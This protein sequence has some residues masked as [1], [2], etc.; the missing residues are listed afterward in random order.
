LTEN[1]ATIL[2]PSIGVGWKYQQQPAQEVDFYESQRGERLA[3]ADLVLNR[4][5]RETLLIELGYS[6]SNIATAVRNNNK[7]RHQRKQTVMNLGS[8]KYEEVLEGV[9]NRGKRLWNPFG[10]RGKAAAK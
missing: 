10:G 1:P 5:Q 6:S 2:G 3:S 8:A 4:E 7:V 9:K